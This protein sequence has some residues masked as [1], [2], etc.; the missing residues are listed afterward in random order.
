M[1]LT[2]GGGALAADVPVKAPPAPP[3]P[4]WSWAGFYLGMQT[5]IFGGRTKFSDPF[6]ASIFGDRA[7]TPG[8][9]LGGQIGYNWQAG[10]WVY[11]LETDAAW[12]GSSS[13]VTC[14]ASSGAYVSSNCGARP[15]A[16]GT[17]TGRIGYALGPAGQTL[18]YAKGGFAWQHTD[19]TATD[20]NPF[21]LV[22]PVVP[23]T[24]SAS[25]TE[26]GWTVGAGV[27]Q[28]LTPA[29]SVKFEYDY[30]NFGSQGSVTI[31]GSEF[32]PVSQQG[33]VFT[34]AKPG[35]ATSKVSSDVHMFKLGLNYKLGHESWS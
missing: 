17:V 6:G 26:A 18:A 22:V 34:F 23:R 20:N 24:N 13:T 12:L 1:V 11:G 25:L 3:V 33:T 10:R 4:A 9:G 27:E 7:S 30:L 2:S 5:D 19:V 16:N 15:D 28:A 31:P 21:A 32:G 35:P 14:G 29:W 8:Y